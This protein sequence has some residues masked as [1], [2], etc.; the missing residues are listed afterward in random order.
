MPPWNAMTILSSL[1]PLYICQASISCLV[2]FMH[3]MPCALV[4]AL[5]RAGNSIPARIAMIAITTS[6]SIKVKPEDTDLRTRV[7]EFDGRIK[8]FHL[9][10]SMVVRDYA[11]HCNWWGGRVKHRK[12]RSQFANPLSG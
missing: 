2:L 6:N 5:A 7:R 12:P 3:R 11:A 10:G 8:A 9:R 4:L 1:S